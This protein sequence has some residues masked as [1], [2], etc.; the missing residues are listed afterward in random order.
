MNLIK[1]NF[2]NRVILFKDKLLQ[3]IIIG[4]KV[5]VDIFGYC[6]FL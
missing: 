5:A 6:T 1:P 3:I 2:L 4:D